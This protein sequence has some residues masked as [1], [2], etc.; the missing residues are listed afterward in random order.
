MGFDYRLIGQ[1]TC[2]YWLSRVFVTEQ[3]DKSGLSSWSLPLLFDADAVDA[4][5]LPVIVY[6]AMHD[7]G[8][9]DDCCWLDEELNLLSIGE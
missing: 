1:L 8:V 3:N 2:L 4:D 5:A 6:V 9:T 7:A